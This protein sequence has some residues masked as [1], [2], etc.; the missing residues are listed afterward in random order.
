MINAVLVNVLESCGCE[1]KK[2]AAIGIAMSTLVEECIPVALVI[3]IFMTDS[4][5]VLSIWRWK[6]WLRMRNC[7]CTPILKLGLS[8]PCGLQFSPSLNGSSGLRRQLRPET[9][10]LV[11]H[12]IVPTVHVRA[13]NQKRDAKREVL[14]DRHLAFLWLVEHSQWM[15]GKYENFSKPVAYVLIFEIV[16]MQQE[17]GD[18]IEWTPQRKGRHLTAGESRKTRLKMLS[19]HRNNFCRR[20]RHDIVRVF[21]MHVQN[22]LW[23][24]LQPVGKFRPSVQ[25]VVYKRF[26]LKSISHDHGNATI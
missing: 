3:A 4:L 9:V 6:T 10:I 5:V 20:R 13:R 24:V 2:S 16:F 18:A 15:R 23:I 17:E 22:W 11:V 7:E 14:K 26:L 1:G 12:W 8:T 25:V 21:L 19:I